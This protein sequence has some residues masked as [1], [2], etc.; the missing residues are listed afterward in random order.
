MFYAIA[1]TVIAT[2]AFILSIIRLRAEMRYIDAQI[3]TIKTTTE[4]AI[5]LTKNLGHLPTESLFTED[6]K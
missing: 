6:D 5:S 2:I 1:I 3:D 4:L